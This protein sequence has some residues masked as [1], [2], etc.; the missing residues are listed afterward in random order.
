M[1]CLYA[2]QSF[3]IPSDQFPLVVGVTSN[4]KRRKKTKKPTKK[5]TAGGTCSKHN[6]NTN[7][8]TNTN[9]NNLELDYHNKWLKLCQL[10]EKNMI[11]SGKHWKYYSDN[12]Q[13]YG[14]QII[15]CPMHSDIL[16]GVCYWLFYKK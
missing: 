11:A 16:N 9:S 14:H 4:K 8:N 15:E 1:E 6:T 12:Y 2:M 3:G 5:D 7:T 13:G 10:K